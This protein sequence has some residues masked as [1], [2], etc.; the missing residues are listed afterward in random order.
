MAPFAPREVYGSKSVRCFLV[1][2]VLIYIAFYAGDPPEE[3]WQGYLNVARK[4][5]TSLHGLIVVTRGSTLSPKQR[6][7]L[8]SVYAGSRVHTAVLTDS[9]LSRGTLTA[10]RWF[11][12]PIA[13]FA[14]DAHRNALRWL[15]REELFESVDA[16]I[17]NAVNAP[18][19]ASGD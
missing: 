10:L 9:I 15:E 6:E 5:A 3:A 14:P 8:R 17:R 7:T 13:G 19:G 4:H 16:V 11:G 18:A 12:I 1:A 2:D